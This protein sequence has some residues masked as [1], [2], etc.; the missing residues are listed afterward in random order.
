M[1]L[2]LDSVSRDWVAEHPAVDC[3]PIHIAPGPYGSLGGWWAHQ[4]TDP[5]R[6]FGLSPAGPR[7]QRPGHQ[8]LA[9]GPQPRAWLQGGAPAA[10]YRATYRSLF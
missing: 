4:G 8:A 10:P 3:H 2:E 1:S 6:L 7:G 5:R 9:Y